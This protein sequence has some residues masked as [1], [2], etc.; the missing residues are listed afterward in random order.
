LTKLLALDPG[1][2]FG[3]AL[4][5]I[6]EVSVPSIELGT[7][8]MP[9]YPAYVGEHCCVCGA[10]QLEPTK[11][12]GERFNLLAQL[13]ETQK[14]LDAIFIEVAPGLRGHAS[15]WHLGYLATVQR[16]AHVLSIPMLTVNPSVW[17]KY[18]CRDGRASKLKIRSEARTRFALFHGAPQDAF[19]ALHVLAWGL[20]AWAIREKVEN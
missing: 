3:W 11:D 14:D 17:K 5:G 10:W 7:Y 19:D 18:T 20:Q 2:S 15:V 13:I 9:N 8:Y 1:E 4:S 6:T 12:S 16:T